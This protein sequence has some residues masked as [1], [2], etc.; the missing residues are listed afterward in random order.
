MGALSSA[1]GPPIEQPGLFADRLSLHAKDRGD[2]T[3]DRVRITYQFIQGGI[4]RLDALGQD[5]HP[6]GLPARKCETFRLHWPSGMERMA[7]RTTSATFAITGREKA[8]GRFH[9]GRN[10]EDGAAEAD[11]VGDQQ[12]DGEQDDQPGRVPQDLQHEPRMPGAVGRSA[13][14]A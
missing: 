1:G 10:E 8:D 6:Q 3:I 9:P 7:P 13:R 4:I 11:F 14:P 2:R 5:D 12:D